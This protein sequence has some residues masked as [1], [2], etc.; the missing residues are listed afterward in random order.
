MTAARREMDAWAPDESGVL[1]PIEPAAVAAPAAQ[2]RN[3]KPLG[4]NPRVDMSAHA[5][6]RGWLAAVILVHHCVL[7]SEIDQLSWA[8]RFLHFIAAGAGMPCFFLLSGFS[9]VIVYGG[10][11]KSSHDGNPAAKPKPFEMGSF[12]RNRMARVLPLYVLCNFVALPLS[13]LGHG[14]WPFAGSRT[15]TSVV[16]SFLPVNMWLPT[17]MSDASPSW[18]QANGSSWS[19]STMTFFYAV[20]PWLLPKLQLVQ[21]KN[22]GRRILQCFCLQLAWW[23]IVHLIL[24]MSQADDELLLVDGYAR[25][26][27]HA[28]F[29]SVTGTGPGRL[30]IFLMGCLAWLA[31]TR[32]QSTGG[33]GFW[34]TSLFNVAAAK[35]ATSSPSP[36]E[37]ARRVDTGATILMVGCGFAASWCNKNDSLDIASWHTAIQLQCWSVLTPILT[38]QLLSDLTQDQGRSYTHRILTSR[39]AGFLGRISTAIYLIHMPV[40]MYVTAMVNGPT[41]WPRLAINGTS[42]SEQDFS[43]VYRVPLSNGHPGWTDEWQA[44]YRVRV[45]PAWT[46]PGVIVISI[47]AGSLLNR[48]V[49]LPARELLR[50]KA[51][52]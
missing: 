16:Y 37:Y 19:L 13:W 22:I 46:I 41:E 26:R 33:L 7:Y 34:G 28:V 15:A 52:L 35:G 11:A 47:V 8:A 23:P 24:D 32:P 3:P 9:M 14:R 4:S 2:H 43:F 6:L 48:F 49:E 20:F 40:L 21:P 51:K 27:C 38:V 1:R 17:M 30:P 42:I 31:R 18:Q 5:G 39:V 44:F 10:G 36:V 45:F 29:W 50:T 12:Y 25:W